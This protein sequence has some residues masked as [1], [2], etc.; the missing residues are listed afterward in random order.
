MSRIDPLNPGQ[1]SAPTPAV[2]L[3]GGEP[4]PAEDFSAVFSDAMMRT[5]SESSLAATGGATALM[6]NDS[7]GYLQSILLSNAGQE[8]ASGNDMLLYMLM[9]MMQEFKNSDLTPLMTA[10]AALMPG[11]GPGPLQVN[12][13]GSWQGN[14]AGSYSSGFL[15]VDAWLPTSF[16]ST[17]T[18]GN[19]S[20]AALNNV[21]RQ[22]DVEN[23]ER[24]RPWRNGSTYCNIFVWDVT[25]ALGCEIPHYVDRESGD[26]RYYPN[27]KG[28]YELDAN[29]VCDWLRRRGAEH[30]WR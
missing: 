20:A 2:T 14:G 18:V 25:R 29:G 28:A 7:L 26:A 5:L 21:I 19:R 6:P 24:Y 23:A 10:L 8:Q 1:E 11:S 3:S 15:P 16:I 12:G 22:F 30:G 4:R 27:I 9:C 17:S 13:P